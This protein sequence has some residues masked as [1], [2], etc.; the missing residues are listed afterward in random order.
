MTCIYT[1]TCTRVHAIALPSPARANCTVL[2]PWRL[3]GR[4]GSVA[5]ECCRSLWQLSKC[6]EQG[7][8]AHA[9]RCWIC[10]CRLSSQRFCFS[11]F[12]VFVAVGA[13][14][15]VNKAFWRFLRFGGFARATL[16]V[17]YTNAF[18]IRRCVVLSATRARPWRFL[19]DS[20]MALAPGSPSRICR[21]CCAP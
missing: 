2:G 13:A 8:V 10:I 21:I 9:T 1:D 4:G 18:V 12:L 15:G 19:R 16:C 6:P 7:V 11:F 17:L 14:L 3:V 5:Q 20:S